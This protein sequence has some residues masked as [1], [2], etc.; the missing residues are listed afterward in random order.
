MR[1]LFLTLLSLHSSYGIYEVVEEFHATKTQESEEEFLN[2]YGSSAE[3][4][5]LAYVCALE[6]KQAEYSF[7]PMTKLKIFN[8]SKNK[9]DSL[10]D[11]NPSN[12]HL[13]YIRFVLQEKAPSLLGYKDNIEQDKKFLKQLLKVS[14]D[15][16]FLD[17][18]I[19]NNTSI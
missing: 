15:T 7:N 8:Q 13:R 11:L 6:M 5:V 1:F 16:D 12:V 3:P 19:Y 14:D 2:K 9:L 18:Y 4:S 17:I 10:I